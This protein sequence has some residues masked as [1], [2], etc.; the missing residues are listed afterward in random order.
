MLPRSS[1]SS[2][3]TLTAPSWP[4]V[5]ATRPSR[6]KRERMWLWTLSSGCR[7]LIAAR[8][9]FRCVAAY[10]AAMPPRPRSTSKCHLPRRVVP[11]RAWARIRVG[12]MA[13]VAESITPK[14]ASDLPDSARAA[15]A[16]V[17]SLRR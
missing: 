13:S 14:C 5:F 16:M 9:P 12:S 2:S 15:P 1:S 7:I 3:R 10:T 6:K 17:H 4:T 11:T 8:V